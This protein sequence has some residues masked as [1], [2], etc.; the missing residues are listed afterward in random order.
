MPGH[1]AGEAM[2]GPL[3]HFTHK[4]SP[5]SS[6]W[7]LWRGRWLKICC[8]ERVFADLFSR[9]D[10]A[11]TD[12]MAS[13]A[14]RTCDPTGPYGAKRSR[15]SWP[16]RKASNRAFGPR[17]EHATVPHLH[18]RDAILPSRCYRDARAGLVQGPD[19]SSELGSARELRGSTCVASAFPACERTR[20]WA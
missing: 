3:V 6:R 11:H 15:A 13:Q 8:C 9:I 10:V 2:A 7:R 17:E 16:A 18:R 12:S 5:W 14:P 19:Q 1:R 4:L 20:A